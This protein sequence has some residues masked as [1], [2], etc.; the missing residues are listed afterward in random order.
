MSTHSPLSGHFP[1]IV[2]G[3]YAYPARRGYVRGT[4]DGSDT[5]SDISD[6]PDHSGKNGDRA[7]RD[8]EREMKRVLAQLDNSLIGTRIHGAVKYG[9]EVYT[10]L[11]VQDGLP[12]MKEAMDALESEV[13][14]TIFNVDNWRERLGLDLDLSSYKIGCS[15]RTKFGADYP[16]M[17]VHVIVLPDEASTQVSHVRVIKLIESQ[18]QKEQGSIECPDVELWRH[19]KSIL[20]SSEPTFRPATQSLTPNTCHYIG[21]AQELSVYD[22]PLAILTGESGAVP[23][24]FTESGDPW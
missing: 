12:V 24:C 23:G 9:L 10:R 11:R 17:S 14:T 8:S 19:R 3:G 20:L 21:T 2:K 4:Y 16:A 13:C 1:Q 22:H 6:K 5:E 15:A 18:E 7:G